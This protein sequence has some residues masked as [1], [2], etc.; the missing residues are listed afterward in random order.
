MCYNDEKEW[1][2]NDGYQLDEKE[3]KSFDD[4]LKFLMSTDDIEDFR[5]FILQW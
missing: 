1:E 2:E 5:V 4:S 3:I